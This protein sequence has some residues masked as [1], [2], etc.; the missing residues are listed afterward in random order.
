MKIASRRVEGTCR[1][2]VQSVDQGFGDC[3]FDMTSTSDDIGYVLCALR[4]LTTTVSGSILDFLA[5]VAIGR[6]L[7]ATADVFPSKIPN[8]PCF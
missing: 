7:I 1:S 3:G 4:H 6:S 2:G 5:G 8:R